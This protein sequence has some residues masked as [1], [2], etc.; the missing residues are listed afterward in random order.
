[1]FHKLPISEG[2]VFFPSDCLKQSFQDLSIR[3]FSQAVCSKSIFFPPE[4]SCDHNLE[5]FIENYYSDTD[6]Y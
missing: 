4:I 5:M 2:T 3:S 1:M 6:L